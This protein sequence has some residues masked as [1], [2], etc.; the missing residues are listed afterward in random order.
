MRDLLL[1]TCTIKLFA[2]QVFPSSFRYPTI[3][4]IVTVPQN[5][6]DCLHLMEVAHVSPQSHSLV[7]QLGS[8]PSSGFAVWRPLLLRYHKQQPRCSKS[9]LWLSTSMIQLLSGNQNLLASQHSYAFL[10]KQ[11]RK[12]Y[13]IKTWQNCPNL[14]QVYNMI[15]WIKNTS[16]GAPKW[17]NRKASKS[18]WWTPQMSK[19]V[20]ALRDWHILS[21]LSQ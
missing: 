3:L 1:H 14:F 21:P 9:S 2:P 11:K 17:H 19:P 12:G 13:T 20:H 6:N 7:A 16:F 5:T 8:L 4:H 15:N 18:W 10:T